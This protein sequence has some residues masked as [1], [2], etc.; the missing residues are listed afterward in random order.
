MQDSYRHT[1]E[2]KWFREGSLMNNNSW[3]KTERSLRNV[4]DNKIKNSNIQQDFSGFANAEIRELLEH[5]GESIAQDDI[6]EWSKDDEG[7]PGDQ[8]LS[9]DEFME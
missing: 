8:F 5:G 6:D 9:M 2:Q 4:T 3:A 7:D 1:M